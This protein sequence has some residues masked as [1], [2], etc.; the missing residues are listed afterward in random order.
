[1]SDRIDLDKRGQL[2]DLV[3]NNVSVARFERMTDTSA[4]ACLY[5]PD[6]TSVVIRIAVDTD[7]HLDLMVEEEDA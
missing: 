2:D 6:G 1:M 3:V 5:R 7:G 4:W